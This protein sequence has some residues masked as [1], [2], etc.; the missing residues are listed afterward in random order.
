MTAGQSKEEVMETNERLRTIRLRL[1]DSYDTAKKALVGLMA[2][3]TESKQ[4]R[5]IF[6]RYNMLKAMIKV[7][8]V[9][10]Y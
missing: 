6:Q 7:I 10:L 5:N 9:F 2:K 1:D 8:K 4:T 3:Y